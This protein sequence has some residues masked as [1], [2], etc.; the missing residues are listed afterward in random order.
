MPDWDARF[1]QLRAWQVAHE[2]AL[3]VYRLARGFP[4]QD[5]YVLGGQMQRA[6]LSMPTNVAEG[7]ARR[8]P[9]DKAYFYMVARSSGEE[10]KSLLLA[11]R[12]LLLVPGP[13]FDAL[14]QRLD[15][16][17]RLIHGMIASMTS[18]EDR[19][20]PPSPPPPDS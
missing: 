12:D 15:E 19:T 7:Y 9:R 8:R 16:A 17:C 2:V 20:R 13:R 6:G 18:W 11:G 5:L 14:M 4:R 3:D 1:M 10:L